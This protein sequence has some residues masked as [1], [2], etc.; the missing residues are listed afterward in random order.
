M[1]LKK[2]HGTVI[3]FF[4]L[5]AIVYPVFF[6]DGYVLQFGINILMYAMAAVSWNII[7]GYAGQLALGNGVYFGI[8]AFVS[9]VLY[10]YSGISPWIG[11]II[12]GLIAGSIS[13]LLGAI[14]FRLKGSYY[15]LST[16]ALLFVIKMLFTSNTYILGFKTNG[17]LGMT[18]PWTGES[19]LHMMFVNKT[20]YYYIILG[21]LVITLVV[22]NYVN[23][24]KMGY[25]LAAINT[26]PD[27]AASLGVNVMGMKLKAGF[28][29]AFLTAVCGTFYA[30]VIQIVDPARVLGYDLSV[31]ILLYAIIGG[32]GTLWGPLMAAVVMVPLNDLLRAQLGSSMSGLSTVI[33]GLALCLIVYF[34]PDGLW[35]PIS[36]MGNNL[37]NGSFRKKPS[38]DAQKEG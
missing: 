38:K 18:I 15:A 21:L 6:R 5:C 20:W 26:N 28:I 17:A 31:Q 35:K 37:L 7:G 32:K 3:A 22:S 16:V 8:G 11:M 33:Y 14:T 2:K 29:S 34:M 24:S 23:K 13:L 19:F 25:Y 10:V 12:A 36:Q 30:F 4:A 9:A 27:A 1:D